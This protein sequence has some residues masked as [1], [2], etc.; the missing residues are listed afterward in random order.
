MFIHTFSKQVLYEKLGFYLQAKT[1]SKLH[2]KINK[3][4]NDVKS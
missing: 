1:S 4:T 3:T 2:F